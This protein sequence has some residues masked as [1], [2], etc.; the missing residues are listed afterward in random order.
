MSRL[1]VSSQIV[2]LTRRG[3][4]VA[5]LPATLCRAPKALFLEHQLALNDFR[6]ALRL[7]LQRHPEIELAEFVTDRD[8][9][10][11]RERRP[12]RSQL[13]GSV[14][15]GDGGEPIRHVPDGK[16]VLR[17]GPQTALFYLEVDRG[18][19]TIGQSGHG[20]GK[21][22]RFYLHL[23]SK[24]LAPGI[25][26]GAE[27][28]TTRPIARL[29]FVTTSRQRIVNVRARWGAR[30]FQPEV[31][32]RFIWLAPCEVLAA[33]DLLREQWCSLDPADLEP[34]V[35]ARPSDHEGRR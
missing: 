2:M 33:A 18:T 14:C 16:F 32:K 15:P 24:P 26:S 22:L 35:I 27:G 9:P 4:E 12:L 11:G 7:S 19:E 30:S 10:D 28:E 21:L 3:A 1:G 5:E 25:E 31:A 20:V 13:A 23:L 8:R 34:Y 6:I 17:R 29:L